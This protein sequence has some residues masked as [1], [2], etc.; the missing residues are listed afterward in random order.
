MPDAGD[1]R[2]RRERRVHED[3][4]RPDPREAVGD[5][6]GVVA[7]DACL[8]EEPG[9][10]AGT[11]VC[12][13]VQ[14]ERALAPKRAP[15]HHGQHPGPGA[16][17]HHDV[18]GPDSGCP[19]RGVGDAERGRE[20]LQAHLGLRAFRVRWLQR[21]ES[22]QHSQHGGGTFWSGSGPVA[23]GPPVAL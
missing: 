13:L 12:Y 1:A 10:E 9:E 18:A 8:G 7:R 21:G 6:L 17:L 20:L 23:H 4:V 19:E 5:G 16:R 2:R 15:A 14:V 3:D 11:G 22:L